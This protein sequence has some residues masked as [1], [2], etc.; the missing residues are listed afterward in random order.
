[1]LE[2]ALMC[3][4]LAIY[5]E[6]RGE[7]LLGQMAVAEVIMNRVNH[8]SWPNTVCGVVK[9]KAQFAFYWDGASDAMRDESAK[10]IASSIADSYI[11]IGN[12]GITGGAT[13]YTTHE[14]NNYWTQQSKVI[15]TLGF[16]KFMDCTT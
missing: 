9:Q 10:T 13:C 3:L 12:P 14:V 15:T 16:H 11:N 5:H 7:P 2:T 6:A 4:T 1:M 8:R